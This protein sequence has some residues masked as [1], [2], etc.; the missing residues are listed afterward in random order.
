MDAKVNGQD[1]NRD[2][3]VQNQQPLKLAGAAV[4]QIIALWLIVTAQFDFVSG[5]T[6]FFIAVLMIAVLA[7]FGWYALTK[8]HVASITDNGKVSHEMHDLP[9]AK[10]RAK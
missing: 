1:I 7:L 10:P 2:W 5:L 6:K 3:I 8:Q 9:H 4:C